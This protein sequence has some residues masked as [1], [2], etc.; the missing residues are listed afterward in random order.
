[1]TRADE[2][3]IRRLAPEEWELCAPIRKGGENDELDAWFF[4]ELLT[5][6]RYT[7]VYVEEGRFL[8][9]VSLVFRHEDP[10]YAIAG[11]RVYVS[12][13]IVRE[14]C[15][16][17]GIGGALLRFVTAYADSLGYTEMALGVDT[18]NTAARALYEKHGFTTVLFRGEDEAGEY[19]K[20]LKRI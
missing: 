18:A 16:G 11:K 13:M 12:R 17:R 19:E 20:R 6:N 1:M 7:F 2:K 15:R 3:H 9:E 4:Q 14:D 10:A 5:G 8:G